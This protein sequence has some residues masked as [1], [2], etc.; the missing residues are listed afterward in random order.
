MIGISQGEAEIALDSKRVA[1][2]CFAFWNYSAAFIFSQ[3]SENGITNTRTS[4]WGKLRPTL[5]YPILDID[6]NL[7]QPGNTREAVKIRVKTQDLTDS[8]VFHDREIDSIAGREARMAEDNLLGTFG[9]GPRDVK[10]LIDD[11]QQ[12]VECRLDGVP[13]VNGDVAMQDLLHDLGV[14]DEALAIID[15]LFE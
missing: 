8:M 15:Q 4:E 12:S 7:R 6:V 14:G 11:A 3:H 13:A 1:Q 10:H 9:G 5:R 2:S